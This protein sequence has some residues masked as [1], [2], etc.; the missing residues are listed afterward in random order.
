[1]PNI[2]FSWKNVS[3]ALRNIYSV[4]FEQKTLNMLGQF[5]LKHSPSPCFVFKMY[6]CVHNICVGSHRIQKNV[7]DSLQLKLQAALI[8]PVWVQELYSGPMKEQQ[9]LLTAEVPLQS[10][11]FLLL[12]LI[13]SSVQ[14]F[15][16]LNE[17]YKVSRNYCII[18]ISASDF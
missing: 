3:Y 1:M 15:P 17:G 4:A 18:T 8:H 11:N 9:M 12:L 16:M 2:G 6:V 13:D 14:N 7:L 5:C 10:S